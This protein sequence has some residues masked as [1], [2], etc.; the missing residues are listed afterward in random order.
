M[1]KATMIRETHEGLSA[2]AYHF[3]GSIIEKQSSVYA[4]LREKEYFSELKDQVQAEIEG[5]KNL[6]PARSRENTRKSARRYER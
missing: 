5:L 1:Q 6:K 3:G 4:N 2:R